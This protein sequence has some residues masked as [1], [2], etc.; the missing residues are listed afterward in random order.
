MG[1]KKI[2]GSYSCWKGLHTPW[3][4]RFVFY[5]YQVFIDEVYFPMDVEATIKRFPSVHGKN[6]GT[7]ESITFNKKGDSFKSWGIYQGINANITD[8]NA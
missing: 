2:D 4:K 8:L 7:I 6:A 3:Y 5:L 1:Y